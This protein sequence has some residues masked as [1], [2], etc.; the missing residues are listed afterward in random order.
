MPILAIVVAGLAGVAAIWKTADGAPAGV[1]NATLVRV[2]RL[3][4]LVPIGRTDVLF[5]MR[6]ARTIVG[7]IH[8]GWA[9]GLLVAVLGFGAG[10]ALILF[11]LADLAV[12]PKPATVFSQPHKHRY[13]AIMFFMQDK[14]VLPPTL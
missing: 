6:A 13:M 14:M 5:G 2:L 1:F 3:P 4:E 12:R 10:S 8:G 9:M 11:L 7:G